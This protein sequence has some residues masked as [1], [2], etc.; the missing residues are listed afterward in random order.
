M[1]IGPIPYKAEYQKLAA[2][3][4]SRN[5]AADQL[6]QQ[7]RLLEAL[8]IRREQMARVGDARSYFALGLL[9]SRLCEHEAARSALE[10]AIHLDPQQPQA[11]FY[12]SRTLFAEAEALDADKHQQAKAKE[13]YREAAQA[14]HRATELAAR[15]RSGVSL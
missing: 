12:L 6:E 13:R 2:T 5:T 9:L 14:A 7:G 15:P 1:G 3:T 4:L 10:K 8:D 11:H